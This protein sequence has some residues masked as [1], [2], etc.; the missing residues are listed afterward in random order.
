MI[1]FFERVDALPDSVVFAIAIGAV[2]IVLWLEKRS[3]TRQERS[4][5]S[6]ASRRGGVA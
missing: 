3:R 5:N 2:F 4:L 6:P 1:A